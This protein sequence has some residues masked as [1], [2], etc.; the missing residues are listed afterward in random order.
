MKIE[1]SLNTSMLSNA[2]VRNLAL[3]RTGSLK[4]ITVFGKRFSPSYYLWSKFGSNILLDVEVS[5]RRGKITRIALDEIECEIQQIW[6]KISDTNVSAIMDIGCGLGM[7]D[8]MFGLT[9]KVSKIALVDI[10]TSDR[11]HHGFED[12]GAGYNSLDTT[13]KFVLANIAKNI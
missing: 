2:D 11:K 1:R 5:F 3:Q 10:E 9:G 6:E 4:G 13:S 12:E 8:V 7:I